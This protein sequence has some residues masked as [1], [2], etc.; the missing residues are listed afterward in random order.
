QVPTGG[1]N[2]GR[3]RVSPPFVYRGDVLVAATMTR[4]PGTLIRA[5]VYVTSAGE[6]TSDASLSAAVVPVAETRAD[7]TGA[8]ELLIPASLDKR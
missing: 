3:R 6:Y 7:D 5:Y 4:V 8:F 2:L 1:L